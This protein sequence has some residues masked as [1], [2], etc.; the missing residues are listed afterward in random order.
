MAHLLLPIKQCSHSMRTTCV[1]KMLN[2]HQATI[3]HSETCR[4]SEEV[5]CIP[6]STSEC[7]PDPVRT[8]LST[9]VSLKSQ[10]QVEAKP[11][12]PC[13]ASVLGLETVRRSVQGQMVLAALRIHYRTLACAD[14]VLD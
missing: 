3:S 1:A 8:E 10:R 5:L 12:F 2:M 13:H 14:L 9:L 7:V 6:M 11:A 4:N